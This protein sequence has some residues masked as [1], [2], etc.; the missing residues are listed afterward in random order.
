MMEIKKYIGLV[1]LVFS[2]TANAQTINFE[3]TAQYK[4]IGI[5]DSW[6]D[7]PFRTGEL[8]GNVKVITNELTEVNESGIAPNTSGKMLAFQR[9]RWASNLYGAR[10]DLNTP[11]QL[12]PENQYVHLYLYKER[13]GRVMLIGLGRR[14][15]RPHQVETEQFNEVY[16]QK[17][18]LGEWNELV[19]PIKGAPGVEVHALV[20]V[21][22][23]ESTH[24]LDSDFAVYIDEIVINN[25][26][27][28][29]IDNQAKPVVTERNQL[30]PG[31]SVKIYRANTTD[32]G[33]NG[34]I[35]KADGSPF[36]TEYIAFGEPYTIQ[37]QPAPGFR[38]SHLII[39]H[40]VNL[41]GACEV[42]GTIQYKEEKIPASEFVNN[43]YT[44]PAEFID[45]DVRIIPYFSSE[46]R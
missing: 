30:K 37:A 46:S 15:E 18:I 33:L 38:L 14:A 19:F 42:G 27:V 32:G 6:I 43:S 13:P 34:D 31:D 25:S 36:T 2:L 26:A 4:A 22:D 20:V 45:G 8:Q 40:G 12:T 11:I 35:L 9:S 17:V 29:R 7:S 39:R 10:I 3:D 1:A 41:E 28:A 21:P 5:Y 44:I 16:T 24:N 23:C